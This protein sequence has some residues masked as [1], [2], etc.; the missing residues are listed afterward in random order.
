M[1]SANWDAADASPANRLATGDKYLDCGKL[2]VAKFAADGTGSWIER[3][4]TIKLISGYASYRFTDKVDVLINARLAADA[5]WA[6]KMDRPQWNG[7][8]P[9]NGEVYFTLTNNSNRRVEPSSSAQSAPDAANLNGH[10]LRLKDASTGATALVWDVYLFGAEAGADKSTS[11]SRTSPMI[12]ILPVP[13][14][15]C[16]ARTRTCAGFRPTMVLIRMSPVAIW[17]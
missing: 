6:T 10:I 8:N 12:W 1:S 7:V 15:W 4:I 14:V 13:T 5:V 2:Y 9:I 3:S 17:W 11:T 16:L